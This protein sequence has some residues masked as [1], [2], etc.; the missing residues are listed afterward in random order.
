MSPLQAQPLP[1]EPYSIATFTA[2]TVLLLTALSLFALNATPAILFFAAAMVGAWYAGLKSTE[3]ELEKER[4]IISQVVGTA[5]CLIVVLDKQGRIVR[6]NQACEKTTGYSF[7][8]VKNKCVWDLFLIPEEVAPVQSVFNQLLK[9]EDFCCCYENYWLTKDGRRRLISWSNTVILNGTGLVEYAIAT[10]TD[11][12]DRHQA[13][14]ALA[15]AYAQLE[16]RVKQRTAELT[17]A[18]EALQAEEERFRSLSSCSPTGIFMADIDGRCTYTN[19]QCQAICGLNL[20]EL[21]GDGWENTIHPED[22]DRVMALWRAYIRNSGQYAIEYRLQ[23]PEGIVRW[24]NVF[25][26]PMFSD[27]GELIGHVGTLQDITER[28]Q[29]QAALSSSERQ[30]KTVLENTPDVIIRTDKELRYVYVNEAVARTQGKPVSYF[31]GK[32]SQELGIPDKLCQMW[33]ETLCK[34]F[35]TGREEIIEFEALSA[36]GIRSYQSRVVPEFDKAGVPESALIVARDITELK[37]AEIQKAQLIAEQ[38]AREKAEIEQGRSA[39][40]AEVSKI[41]ATAFNGETALQNVAE[42]AVQHSADG[43]CIHL[44]ETEGNVRLA[45]VAHAETRTV[46]TLNQFRMLD[47]IDLNFANG[48]PLVIRT[49]K[50]ELIPEVDEAI[51]AAAAENEAELEMLRSLDI[52]SHACVPLTARGRVMGAI[53]CFTS[54]SGRRYSA[55]DTAMLEDLAYRVAIALDNAR[56]YREAQQALA[57]KSESFA[58]IDS[59][60]EASPLGMCFFDRSMR[61][62]RINQVLAE[63]NGLPAQQHLGQD[64]RQLLPEVAAKFAPVVQQVLDTGEPI[65]NLEISGEPA[66]KPGELR[67]WLGNYYPVK[68]GSGEILGAGIILTDITAAK[69]TEIALQESETRFRSV[70]ESQM[71]GIG[72]WDIDGQVTDA[73][74]ALLE[75]IGA[76]REEL[77]AGNLRWLELT[78]PEQQHLDLAALAQIQA[79]GSCTPFE[80]EYIRSDGSRFPVLVGGAHFQG[81]KDKGSFFVLDITDRKLA[82]NQIRENEARIARQLAELDLVY[83]T[84]P[85]GL[86]FVDTELRYVRINDYL[87]AI[88]GRPSIDYIGRTVREAMPETA[89]IVEPIYRQVL[90]S[91]K[92]VLDLE[93]QAETRQQPGVLRDWLVSFY[94]VGDASGTLLGISTVVQ[95][96]TDRKQAERAMRQS[97]I[98]FRRLL[99]ADIFGVAIGD[100]TGRI[101]YANDTLLKMVG[102]SRTDLLSGQMPWD[103]MTSPEYLHLDARA[104]EELRAKG[105]ATPFK[106]EYIRKDG[107]R[108][109]VL[110]GATI[111]DAG[112]RAPET[113]MGFYIDLTEIERLGAELKI[114]RERLQIAQQAGRIGTFE[115]NVQ[116]DEFTGTPEL[117]ALYGL[118]AGG[119]FSYESWAAAVHPDDRAFAQRQ[120]QAAAVSGGDLDIEFRICR[121]DGSVRWMA[122]RAIVFEDDGGLP[123]RAIGVN[124]DISE[125]K[126]AEAARSSLDRTLSALIRACPLAITVFS[127]QDASV[128]MWNPA[129]ERI[130]GWKESE[131]IGQFLPS[132]PADKRQEFAAKLKRIREG[133]KIEGMETRRQRKDGSPID[134]ALWAT[135]VCT[136][137]NI[138]CMSIVADISDRKQAEAERA[139]VLEREQAARAEAEANSRLKDEFLATLSHELRTPLNTILGWSQILRKGGYTQAVLARAIEAIERQARVQMQLVED[140][141]DVSRMVQGKLVLKPGWFDMVKTIEGALNSVKFQAEAKPV[142]VRSELD[143]AVGLMWGDAPKLQQV[144]SNLLDNAVKFT[145]P[146]GSVDLRVSSCRA[147]GE[148]NYLQIQV[149]DNG[150]G[151]SGE[152][153]PYVF[154]R[155]RQADGSITRASGGLGLGLAI[156]RHLVELHGGTVRAASPGEEQGATFT[157]LLP[158]KQP[159]ATE[160]IRP[161]PEFSGSGRSIGVPPNSAV[162]N[163]DP[164][165]VRKQKHIGGDVLACR[166]VLVVDGDRHNREFLA[167]AVEECGAS[168]IAAAS[169]AE[170]IEILEDT[171][172]DILVSDIGMPQE[173]GYSLIRK[174]RASESPRTKRLPAVAL[175]AYAGEQERRRAIAAGYDEHLTKPIE[176][177]EFA[178]VLAK[179]IAS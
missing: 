36:N 22:R 2:G 125:R 137:G 133:T 23:T 141:L 13:E 98:L 106:K 97:E 6:F 69:Q 152:F 100:F 127:A 57:Q 63:I 174:I 12:T 160:G 55:E 156:V 122:C 83:S 9:A 46:D 44:I 30:L 132:V 78:P 1:I 58:L 56:L 66:G 150:K 172:P 164:S 139:R 144:V 25:C 37:L 96:I 107:S 101:A 179:L 168:A 163:S 45:A 16:T 149:S 103:R 19:P 121:P 20:A 131:A 41:L 73:N 38:T 68:D 117:E 104:A 170:A 165:G 89:D 10:G 50:S 82:Q 153:L 60:L 147:D 79:V 24:V 169:A 28:Q 92:P 129:A 3:Q 33:D 171:K 32:T 134:I 124:V 99:G 157:V 48:Y 39:F 27:S 31:L 75:M 59:L 148:S 67:Y 21:L 178:A 158:L 154:D 34:V 40:L 14:T 175:T 143:P 167:A 112:D 142:T 140:L 93:I 94:P 47:P 126:Q 70:V 5:A 111:L 119:I 136:E 166:S 74:D 145:Q 77:V 54:K 87:A 4:D 162:E 130:F 43:C 18:K 26:S 118:P 177:A 62:I 76:S 85:V 42:L 52:G 105:V 51:L 114:D 161:R 110:V 155:F 15:V 113:V 11:I 84:A 80:K 151:I 115:W 123:L 135:P 86:C 146:G 120:M 90:A 128:K 53:T 91:Q 81:C 108:V 138:D 64:F 17:V 7:A 95:E 35:R 29:A 65:L 71:I 116:T 173:D 88:D 72:F 61:Y 109:P 8:E 176:P 159:K 102:Y 49:G